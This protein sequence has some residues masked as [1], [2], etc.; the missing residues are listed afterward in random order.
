LKV[1]IAGPYSQ[2]DP[3]QNTRNAILAAEKVKARGHTPYIPHLNLLWHMV[4]PH[5]PDFWYDYDLEWLPDC[6]ALLRLPGK[7]QGA[8]REVEEA[9]RWG[10]M[11]YYSIEDLP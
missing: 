6:D 11:I 10:R 1:Y 2:G 7:S 8:D 4:S 5:D 3:I 9:K